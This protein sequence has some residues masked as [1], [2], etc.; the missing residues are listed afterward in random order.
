MVGCR[1]E[2]RRFAA[3]QSGGKSWIRIGARDRGERNSATPNT[4]AGG[5]RSGRACYL[6]E[7]GG[8]LLG[9][10]VSFTR[11][12]SDHG[13]GKLERPGSVSS[14][15]FHRPIALQIFR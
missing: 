6:K 15:S 5:P 1:E 12:K 14:K 4:D 8:R 7:Q 3:Q 10:Q 9:R 11:Q 2:E 13:G